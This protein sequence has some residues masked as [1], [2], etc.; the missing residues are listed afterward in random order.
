ME[1]LS[2]E[3]WGKGNHSVYLYRVEPA[4][5][6]GS[7]PAYVTK[8][9][10]P[11]SLD[12]IQREYGGGVWR[13][14]IK[15]G[16]ERIVDRQYTVGGLPMD[17][18]RVV[19]GNG[20]GVAAA[21]PAGV[22]GMGGSEALVSKAIDVAA[23][24]NAQAAQIEMVKKTNAEMLELAK[25]AAPKQM[26]IEEIIKLAKE[27]QPAPAAGGIDWWS[28]PLVIALVTKLAERLFA[29][30]TENFIKL[31]A[32]S[33]E[34]NGGSATGDWK[35]AL[36]Q[37]VPKV[38]ESLADIMDSIRMGAEAQMRAR[39]GQPAALPAAPTPP[40]A[41]TPAPAPGDPA[42]VVEMPKPVAT[43]ADG[44]EAFERRFVE[45]L[46]DPQVTG[47]QAAEILWREWPNILTEISAYPAQ[48]VIANAFKRPLL[49]P[50]A[51]DPR[52]P[53]FLEEMIAWTKQA[54]AQSKPGA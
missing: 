15:R 10:T 51:Q 6:R 41:A 42:N 2:P 13:I 36:A 26:S 8:Y 17:L 37:A 49:V 50:Y 23:N 21:T 11:V 45:L 19:G 31:L 16:D 33:K 18:S 12:M 25:S 44:V 4:V 30:P 40:A 38:G 34:M 32:L 14:L 5:Y 29:D 24:T 3:D 48:V 39:T 27:L 47:A 43:A 22:G 53:Q 35:L 46:A 20:N 52:V 54:I 1:S 7:G 9:A 28:N